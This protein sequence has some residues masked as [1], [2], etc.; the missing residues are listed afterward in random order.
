MLSSVTPALAKIR[1]RLRLRLAAPAAVAIAGFAVAAC[2]SATQHKAAAT[3]PTTA[4][5]PTATTPRPAPRK[6]HHAVHHNAAPHVTPA[7]ALRLR[8]RARGSAARPPHAYGS[9]SRPAAAIWLAHFCRALYGGRALPLDVR[10]L[11]SK[12]R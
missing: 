9:A 2:G 8:V 5:T 4:T 7:A 12:N 11:M 6:V 10:M 3:T 1:A